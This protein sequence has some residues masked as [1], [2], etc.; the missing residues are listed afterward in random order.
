MKRIEY[1]HKPLRLTHINTIKGYDMTFQFDNQKAKE[2]ELLARAGPSHK[3]TW[4]IAGD[5]VDVDLSGKTIAASWVDEEEGDVVWEVS[6]NAVTVTAD[7]GVDMVQFTTT[8]DS[9]SEVYWVG[10]TVLVV[11]KV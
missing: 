10:E 6:T 3:V 9:I 1:K 11:E 2:V 5:L 8:D 7:G 4:F